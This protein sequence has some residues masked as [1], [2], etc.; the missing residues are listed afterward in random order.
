MHGAIEGSQKVFMHV[1][2]YV[3]RVPTILFGAHE[4]VG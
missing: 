3:G 1:V 4:E 2:P